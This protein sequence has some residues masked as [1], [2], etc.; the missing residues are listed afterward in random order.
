MIDSIKGCKNTGKKAHPRIIARKHD[1]HCSAPVYIFCNDGTPEKESKETDTIF[2]NK[3]YSY[4][5][6]TA[7]AKA[8]EIAKKTGIKDVED[9]RQDLLAFLAARVKHYKPHRGAPATFIELCLE[10][11]KKNIIRNIYRKRKKYILDATSLGDAPDIIDERLAASRRQEFAE[12]I[13]LLDQPARE[14]CEGYFLNGAKI[15]DISRRIK[16]RQSVI[17]DVIRDAM[18]PLAESLGIRPDGP[19]A[20]EGQKVLPTDRFGIKSGGSSREM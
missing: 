7:T 9:F 3:N 4:I 17:R 14:I 20:A 10:S 1:N 18:R 13:Q 19:A 6:A 11:G 2:F 8:V 16:I 12:F 5:H 15:G